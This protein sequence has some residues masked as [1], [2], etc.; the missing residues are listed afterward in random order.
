M[1][2]RKKITP[3]L[4]RKMIQEEKQRLNETLELGLKHPSEAA[5]RTREVDANKYASTLESCLDHYKA[6]KLKE[7]KLRRELKKIQETKRRLKAKLIK[8][9]D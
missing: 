2:R 9:L 5:K 4:I 3:S 1:S 8:N 6:C 7:A